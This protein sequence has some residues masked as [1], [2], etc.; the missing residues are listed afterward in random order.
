M[1]DDVAMLIAAEDNEQKKDGFREESFDVSGK[2]AF[3]TPDTINPFL[4]KVA[5]TFP[6]HFKGQV[7][8]KNQFYYSAAYDEPLA[9][10]RLR[11][12]RQDR[13]PGTVPVRFPGIHNT[14]STSVKPDGTLISSAPPWVR[15]YHATLY[16]DIQKLMELMEQEIQKLMEH[17]D[18][19]NIQPG[20]W[21]AFDPVEALFKTNSG[22]INSPNEQTVVLT[23]LL[24]TTGMCFQGVS[25]KKKDWVTPPNCFSSLIDDYPT[26]CEVCVHDLSRIKYPLEAFRIYVVRTHNET[27]LQTKPR[28]FKDAL[29][30]TQP[31]TF[32]D[33]EYLAQPVTGWLS[34]APADGRT[35][36]TQIESLV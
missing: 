29:L 15:V 26:G 13:D 5:P 14:M 23:T 27:I 11:V 32:K 18:P 1:R 31:R 34:V 33:V 3:T 12:D 24:D 30:Q 8:E 36:S 6:R 19:A 4:K 28:T 35:L 20:V 25:G 2:D 9:F 17:Q 21:F 16:K 10:S 7:Y 22:G